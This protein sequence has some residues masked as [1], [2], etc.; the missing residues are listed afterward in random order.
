MGEGNE[1]DSG[2]GARTVVAVLCVIG[3]IL[4]VGLSL[5]RFYLGGN[6]SDF[7][8]LWEA[9]RNALQGE[10]IYTSRLIFTY[11]PHSL[12]LFA[13]F[14]LAPFEWG[15]ILFN[16][17]GLGFFALAAK[18][19]LPRGFPLIL[20]I[21]S[22]AT[23]FCLL[24]GQS[25]LFL[26]G[27]WL[28]AFRGRWWAVAALSFKPHVGLLGILSLKSWPDVSRTTILALL[29]ITTSAFVFGPGAW[30]EFANSLFEQSARIGVRE[31]WFVMGVSPAHGYGLWGWLAFAVPAAF[32]LST[33]VTPFTAA[34]AA[35][36]ISPYGFHYDMAVACFGF[37]IA[38][39]H[40]WAGMRPFYRALLVGGFLTPVIVNGGT[41]FAP[42]ILLGALWVQVRL[43]GQNRP[44]RTC[45][46]S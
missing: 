36:L 5:L 30:V 9:G 40:H 11:P 12:F 7:W 23:F 33:N 4:P 3:A 18:P 10:S 20:A 35:M 2:S 28:L 14:G 43:N 37:A 27:F 42:P 17:L 25:G 16:F 39:Y 45:P 8:S 31:Q 1:L 44:P 21:G 6:G 24:I 29:L 13:P 46:A 34:T 22:P 19:Y 41:W 15:L 32:L 26:A 38:I